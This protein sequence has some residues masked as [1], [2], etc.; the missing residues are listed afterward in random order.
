MTFIAWASFF[1][2]GGGRAGFVK[3]VALNL[4]GLVIASLTLLCIATTSG[5]AVAVA[6][7]VGIGQRGDGSGIQDQIA[8]RLAC[9]RLGLRLDGRHDG[10]HR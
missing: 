4:T 3:S 7:L 10:G 9:D 8:R 5:G 6:V 2:L 1:V